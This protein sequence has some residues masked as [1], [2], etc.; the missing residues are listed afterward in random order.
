MKVTKEIFDRAMD[1]E[2][3]HNHIKNLFAEGKTTG[4][5]Q[6]PELVELTKLNLQ[7]IKRGLKTIQVD[8][9]IATSLKQTKASNWLV[10]IEA[11]CGDGANII[12]SIA[13]MAE[14][15]DN[16][17]LR[18]ILRD[19]NPEIMDNYLTNGA[20]SIPIVVFFDN[21]FNELDRWGARPKPAQQLVIDHKA[22][23]VKS[24]DEVKIDLQKWYLQ[25]KGQTT[26]QEFKEILESFK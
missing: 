19:D 3:Y 12:P 5:R 16:I 15:E 9:A 11:W 8:E 24:F 21:D 20:K 13:K 25:D 18:V 7:R 14:K 2:S 22:N 10:I 4:D 26:Q 6:T 23:P 1:F 17:S